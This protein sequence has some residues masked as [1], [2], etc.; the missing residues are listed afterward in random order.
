MFVVLDGSRHHAARRIVGWFHRT[1]I[2]RFWDGFDISCCT[3]GFLYK[4]QYV[5]FIFQ[6]IRHF[7]IFHNAP[8]LHP[9]PPHQCSITFVFHFSWVLR[10]SQEKLKTMLKQN[11]WGQIRCIMRNV[12]LA[13]S[14]TTLAP[15][16]PPP[17]PRV[18]PRAF[19]CFEN[20]RPSSPVCCHFRWSNAPPASASKSVISPIHQR[21]FKNVLTRQTVHPNVR[22]YPTKDNRNILRS[23]GKLF[24]AAEVCSFQ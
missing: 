4:N 7:H 16:A 13:Y 6:S 12:A 14:K 19:D 3:L 22:K 5:T 24:Y 1:W 20:F 9:P 23:L 15:A 10:L 21:L 18:N 2:F 11:V 8:Y 17:P